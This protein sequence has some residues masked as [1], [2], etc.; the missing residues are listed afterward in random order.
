M[1]YRIKKYS[2][3]VSNNVVTLSFDVPNGMVISINPDDGSLDTADERLIKESVRLIID[4][5]NKVVLCSSMQKNRIINIY[6]QGNQGESTAD[7]IYIRIAIPEDKTV[8]ASDQFTIEMDWG[9]TIEDNIP[10]DYAKETT[11]QQAAADAEAAKVAAQAIT[12]YATE[13]NATANKNAIIAEI[14]ANAGIPTLTIPDSTASQELVPNVL[15][16][17]STRTS[18][19]TLT[20][21][22]PIVGIANEYH[23]F[24]V[25]GST[26]PTVNFP[27]G[28]TW[29]GGIA[30]TIAADKTC[31][32]S[33]LNNVAAYFDV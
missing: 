13:A 31:E 23:F 9:D 29:N 21:G 20:L 14:Q 32:V 25:C 17:F 5:T 8:S 30:P 28:I 15:Y 11:A 6:A 1:R 4:E 24:I 22:T 27:T 18:T 16:I 12:G 19:L 26:A 33:I 7:T 3:S 10:T 2:A